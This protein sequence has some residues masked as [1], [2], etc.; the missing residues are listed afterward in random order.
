MMFIGVDGIITDNLSLLQNTIRTH[1]D[2]PSYA[3]RMQFFSNSL[4]NISAQ[5]EVD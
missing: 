1:D 4:D 5:S 3:E 2:H